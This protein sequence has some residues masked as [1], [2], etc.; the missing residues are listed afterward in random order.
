M[1]W[2]EFIAAIVDHMAWPVVV[3]V[4]F[5]LVRDQIGRL[6]EKLAHLKY[7][8]LELDFEKVKQQAE[9]IEQPPAQQQ[10]TTPEPEPVFT[11]LE[12]QIL[13]TVEKAPAAAILLSWSAV[14]T[15][16]ASA[17]ARLSISTESPSYRSPLHNIEMLERHAELSKQHISLLHEMR[18]L[19][20]KVAH[21][22]HSLIGISQNQALDYA[23]TAIKLVA[24]LN[25]LN[26]AHKTYHTPTGKWIEQPE[27]FKQHPH[28]R[29]ASEWLYSRINLGNTGLAAGLGPWKIPGAKSAGYA[30]YGIDIEMPTSRGDQTI[31]ELRMSLDYV[32]PDALN[33]KASDLISYDPHSKVVTF[34]LGNSIFKYRINEDG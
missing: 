1:N 3:I 19:R 21:D 16:L 18:M 15:A 17:T 12:E 4:M 9:S 23:N 33:K 29:A 20:N 30:Y 8:D 14:E 22:Q 27:G 24:T 13:E 28:S 5:V 26:R 31:A 2:K 11:S 25:S 10:I 32:S 6:I 34:D 7:K